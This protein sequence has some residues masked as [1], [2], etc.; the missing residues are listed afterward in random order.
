MNILLTTIGS[1]GEA[2]PFIGVGRSLRGRGHQVT[3]ITNPHF[4]AAVKSAG[5]DFV[6]LERADPHGPGGFQLGRRLARL[7]GSYFRRWRKLARAGSTLPYLRPLYAI[8]ARL[9][10]PGKTLVVANCQCLGARVAQERMGVPLVSVL[11]MPFYLRSLHRPPVTPPLEFPRWSPHWLRRAAYALAD[12]LVLDRLLMG[13]V[14]EFRAELDLPPE[15]HFIDWRLSPERTIGLFPDWYAPPQPDWPGQ[16]RL[17]GFPLFDEGESMPTPELEDFL[18]EGPPPLVFTAG[19]VVRDVHRFFAE[20]A[21][22]CRLLRRRGILLTRFRD[23]VPARLPAGTRHFDYVPYSKL[24]PRAAAVVHLGGIGGTAQCLRAGVPQ[25]VMPYK[26]DQPD[27]AARLRDLGVC[28]V[29][30]PGAYRAR[31]VASA[32]DSLL[33]SATVKARCSSL[34]SQI[35][36]QDDLKRTCDLIEEMRPRIRTPAMAHGRISSRRE[37]PLVPISI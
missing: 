26:N 34:A 19:S 21:E 24:L 17:T 25:L 14:N 35:D 33:Q 28:R 20:S 37:I 7:G 10:E 30:A 11:L 22:A 36:P 15:D 23:Q 32:I 5:L 12:R 29:L 8:I 13:P 18:N 9:Y 2:H 6:P 3:L 1:S 4:E 16:V 31:S 27:N